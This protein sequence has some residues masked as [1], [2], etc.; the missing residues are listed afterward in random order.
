MVVEGEY[1]SA[2]TSRH[3][4]WLILGIGIPSG[5][6]AITSGLGFLSGDHTS[7]EKN[8]GVASVIG[9]GVGLVTSLI[10][11]LILS[12]SADEAYVYARPAAP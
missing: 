8:V 10:M 12:L 11:G 3:A 7:T 2:A 6:A 1:Q 4:G 9:G 5:L